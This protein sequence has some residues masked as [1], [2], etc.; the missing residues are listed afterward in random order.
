MIKLESHA[1]HLGMVCMLSVGE[2]QVDGTVRRLEIA[3]GNRFCPFNC[4]VFCSWLF[5]PKIS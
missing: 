2:K 4:G 3:A 5:Y 1:K